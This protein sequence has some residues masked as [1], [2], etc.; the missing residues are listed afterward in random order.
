VFETE[1]MADLCA[2]QGLVDQAIDI[3]R[4]LADG[5]ADPALRERYRN[6]ISA[7]ARDPAVAVLPIPGLR[8]R[9][10]EGEVEIEWRLPVD[11]AAPGLQ[12][13]FLRRGPNG[14]E[15]DA[16]T[17][18]LPS[19]DGRLTLPAAGLASVRAAAGRLEDGGFVPLVRF[20]ARIG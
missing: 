18:S 5:A 17:L 14:I 13:L 12:V 2:R 19:T 11:L 4:R 8:L 6:R 10:R 9:E 1:T 3:L 16:R 7:L 15:S 20:P